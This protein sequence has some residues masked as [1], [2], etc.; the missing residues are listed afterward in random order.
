MLSIKKL[1]QGPLK[2]LIRF[3]IALNS[4][5][6]LTRVQ[7]P[8]S[9]LP[10][11]T[12]DPSS[13]G[14]AADITAP[15]ITEKIDNLSLEKS[16]SQDTLENIAQSDEDPAP[17][18]ASD[19]SEEEFDSQPVFEDPSDDDD[20]EGEWI[21]P[22]NVAIHKSRAL[23]LL[24]ADDA[25]QRRGKG[26]GSEDQ[27]N[28]MAGCMTADFAMQ[29]VLLHMGLHLIGVGGKRISQV[30]TWVLRCHGCFK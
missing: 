23:D 21:T 17:E 19:E 25:Q 28:I 22:E 29:N 3:V 11:V 30:K 7:N 18:S 13:S 10:A 16:T 15:D 8:S 20:G 12:L 9:S 4:E 27:Q 1:K 2:K 26:K 5:C 14:T 6:A 24:P